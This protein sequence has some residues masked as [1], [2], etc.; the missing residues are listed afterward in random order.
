MLGQFLAR[1]GERGVI[2]AETGRALSLCGISPLADV[3]V[4]DLSTGQR[5]LVELARVVAGAF[6]LLLLD[7]PSSGLDHDETR[8]FGAVLQDLV[9]ERGTG[10]LL[11]EHD[12]ALVMAVCT[13]IYVLDFG[14][15]IFAGTPEEVAASPT[16]REAYLGYEAG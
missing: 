5:R 3:A 2:D 11:V 7:E 12:M 15:L 10:I 4:R 14:K 8:A 6:S 13:S 16:V 1:R 9:A